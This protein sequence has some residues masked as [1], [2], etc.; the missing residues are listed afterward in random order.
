MTHDI[1]IKKLEAI[2]VHVHFAGKEQDLV[3]SRIKSFILNCFKKSILISGFSLILN[4]HLIYQQL[5]SYEM[6]D[7]YVLIS[8][9]RITNLI[10]FNF[11]SL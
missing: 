4:M 2:H 3:S 6:Y 1:F 8:I 5:S 9:K 11:L 10:Q 7:F